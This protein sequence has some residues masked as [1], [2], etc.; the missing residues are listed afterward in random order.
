MISIFRFTTLAW[1]SILRVIRIWKVRKNQ[2]S[3]EVAARQRKTISSW[4]WDLQVYQMDID[5]LIIAPGLLPA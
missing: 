3:Y 1:V 2:E 5:N 4:F